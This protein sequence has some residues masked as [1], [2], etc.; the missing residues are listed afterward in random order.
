MS[1][2]VA[3]RARTPLLTLI[4]QESLDRDY[5]LVASRRTPDSP[6]GP[7][8]RTAVVVVL[9][10][11]AMLVT[12]AGVQT[13]RNAQADDASRAGLIK[14][15]QDRRETVSRLQEKVADLRRTNSG[16]ESDLRRLGERSSAFQARRSALGAVTGFGRVS[17]DGVQV[18]LDN[19]PYADKDSLV[20]DSDLAL[21]V[22]GL[23]S[24]GAEAV[25][26][27]GQRLTAMSA[28]RNSGDAIEVN[29]V[30][31]AP[32]Y[33]VTAIGDGRS[34]S[35]DFITSRSGQAF[36]ALTQQFGFRYDMDNVESVEL[37]AAPPAQRT[38]RSVEPLS[39]K[40]KK[41]K[42]QGGNAP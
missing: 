19:A 12:V 37:P 31:I 20:R 32:P 28:I 38:L 5:Q 4:T 21:L 13:S 7:G 30:G 18:S 29:R 27:N 10:I 2:T 33:T 39:K 41:S 34:L 40:S 25:A 24:A 26:V 8:S 16:A 35:A 11:F 1:Q 22:N 9:A 23:W 36:V 3:D 14:R 42:A 6:E 15:I 17:G